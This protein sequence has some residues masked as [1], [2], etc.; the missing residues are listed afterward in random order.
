MPTQAEHKLAPPL[1]RRETYI[2][3]RYEPDALNGRGDWWEV[4]AWQ[5]GVQ[6]YPANHKE[7]VEA[8]KYLVS[9]KFIR[10]EGVPATEAQLRYGFK[11]RVIKETVSYVVEWESNNGEGEQ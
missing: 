1:P 9:S 11:H 7:A 5:G 4:R 6:G 2:I 10:Q 8:A 3:Q